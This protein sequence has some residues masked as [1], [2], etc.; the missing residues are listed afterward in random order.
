MNIGPAFNMPL[1]LTYQGCATCD[2]NVTSSIIV[3]NKNFKEAVPQNG[4]FFIVTEPESGLLIRNE[5]LATV[6]VGLRPSDTFAFPDLDKLS[7]GKQLIPLYSYEDSFR[8]DEDKFHDEFAFVPI[9]QESLHGCTVAFIVLT[10]LFFIFAVVALI[11]YCVK[12][13]P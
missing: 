3:D 2:P 9:N 6:F 12:I 7:A 4:A 1:V 5:K 13:R 11:F 10:I 8:I